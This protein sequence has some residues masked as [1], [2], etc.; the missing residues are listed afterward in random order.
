MGITL[1]FNAYLI[2]ELF[3]FSTDFLE[4]ISGL[5]DFVLNYVS[6]PKAKTWQD[7]L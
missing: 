2:I 1:W 3:S 5:E 7:S 4:R 6:L